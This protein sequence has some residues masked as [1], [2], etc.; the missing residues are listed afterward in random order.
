VKYYIVRIHFKDCLPIYIFLLNEMTIKYK[1]CHYVNIGYINKH[2]SYIVC[3]FGVLFLKNV[4]KIS[5]TALFPSI[6]PHSLFSQSSTP[7]FNYFHTIPTYRRLRIIIIYEL[8]HISPRSFDNS[9][10]RHTTC[11]LYL[12]K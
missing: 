12:T 5:L 11:I 6:F 9:C 1:S 4:D 10:K 2:I 3:V 7:T 8:I